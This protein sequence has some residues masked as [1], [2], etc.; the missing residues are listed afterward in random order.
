MAGFYESLLGMSRVHATPGLVVLRSPD[1][2]LTLHAISPSDSA[3]ITITDPPA[4][5]DN[6]A[7]KF[8]FT[9]P[10][11]AEA[12]ALA[13]SLGGEV[14]PEQWQGPGFTVCNAVDPEGNLFQVRESA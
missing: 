6:A 4:R 9:V 7:F 2:Q 5:R 14:L 13:P 11:L 10:S 3:S 12:E 1:I 8:F